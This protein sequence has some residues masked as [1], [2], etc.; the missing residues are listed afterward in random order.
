MQSHAMPHRNPLT[1]H[2]RMGFSGDM[3]AAVVLNVGAR[4]NTNKMHISPDGDMKPDAG[5]FPNLYIT[6]HCRR[7]GNKSTGGDSGILI[8]IGVKSHAANPSKNLDHRQEACYGIRMFFSLS[9]LYR[10]LGYSLHGL[11]AAWIS[12]AA[13]RLE[14]IL[15]IMALVVAAWVPVTTAERAL[16]ILSSMMVLGAELVNTA[17]ESTIN[18]IG[19]EIHPLSKKAKDI[20]S[21]VVL[22]ALLQALLVWAVILWPLFSAWI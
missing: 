11:R 6:N 8:T 18:R 17:I 14:V 21:T 13:F 4:P 10:A 20:G 1:D 22:V 5:L 2:R 15:I 12:E 16:L 7:G 9:R 19:P 3:D